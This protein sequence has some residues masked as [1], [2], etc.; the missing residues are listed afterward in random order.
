M[1]LN[2]IRL[3]PAVA[4]A[5]FRKSIVETSSGEI[6]KKT[7][8][9]LPVTEPEWKYLGDNKKNILVVVDHSGITHLP[10]EELNFLTNILTACKL[11]LADVAIINKQNYPN[12]T[13]K[14]ITNH[15]SCKTVLLFG[16]DPAEFGLPV[17]FPHFQVQTFTDS[18]FLFSPGLEECRKDKLLK[19]KLWV[20]LQRIFGIN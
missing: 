14:E 9:P 3:A 6:I 19:S 15:F 4:A 11:S 7:E 2:D 18:T 12:Q 5:L 1:G 20:C 10:D 8:I 13:Y 17:S 16:M